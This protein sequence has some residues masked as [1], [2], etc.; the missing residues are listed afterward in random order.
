MEDDM[1]IC[2]RKVDFSICQVMKDYP[3][4]I[5][6]IGVLNTLKNDCDILDLI[7]EDNDYKIVNASVNIERNECS[8]TIVAKIIEFEDGGEHSFFKIIKHAKELWFENKKDYVVMTLV[9]GDIFI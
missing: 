3:N 5:V 4:K 6:R 1:S 9:Y 2:Y 7:A 8:I